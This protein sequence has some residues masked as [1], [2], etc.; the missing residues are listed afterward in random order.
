MIKG[1]F[2]NAICVMSCHG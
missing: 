2:F 1:L